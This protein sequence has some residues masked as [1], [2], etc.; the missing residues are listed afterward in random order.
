MVK[1]DTSDVKR[2]TILEMDGGLYRVVDISHTHMG[3]QGAT[4]GFKVKEVT[5]GKTKVNTYNAG[6]VLEQA[7]VSTMNALYLYHT[8]DA[9]SFM[10]G[11]TGEMF[12]VQEDIIDDMSGYLKDNMDVFLM[13]YKGQV[14]NVILPT[15]VEYVI[16]NTVPG[17]KGDRSNAGK[18]PAT[19]ETGIEIQVPLHKN[20]GDTITVN[21]LTGDVN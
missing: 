2:G 12:E 3:R 10:V 18:K 4:Y 9:Y 14:I 7:D 11:D 15:T 20:E 8:G 5:T 1:I 21:T 6:T 16:T 17:L 13:M 19:I